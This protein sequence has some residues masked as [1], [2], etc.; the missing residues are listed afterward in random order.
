MTLSSRLSIIRSRRE[1]LG[2]DRAS[3][4][5]RRL[6]VEVRRLGDNI[7]QQQYA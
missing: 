2:M 5:M 4:P 3:E 1:L 7:G 6:A